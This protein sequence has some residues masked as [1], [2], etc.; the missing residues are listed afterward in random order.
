MEKADEK[1]I[2]WIGPFVGVRAIHNAGG[3]AE[4][5]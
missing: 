3:R 2:G 1:A 5:L 4:Q